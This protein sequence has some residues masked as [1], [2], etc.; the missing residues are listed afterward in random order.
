[1]RANIP[2]VDDNKCNWDWKLLERTGC[3]AVPA[4]E[5][6]KNFLNKIHVHYVGTGISSNECSGKNKI[7]MDDDSQIIR[8]FI[9]D[10][11]DKHPFNKGF[12][13]EEINIFLKH[14][15]EKL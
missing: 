1:M 7:H 4:P 13:F 12:G 11:E 6:M 10:Y 8:L 14:K 9:L 3:F 5:I 15:L 2:I